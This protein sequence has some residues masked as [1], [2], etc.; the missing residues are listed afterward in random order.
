MGD[1]RVPVTVITGFLGAGK[2]TLL[3]HI[4]SSKEHGLRFAV[5]ENEFGDVSIDDGI[6]RQQSEE[7][8][9]EM[10]NGCVCCTVRGD[11]VKVVKKLLNRDGKKFDAILLETTGMADPS[12]VA[13]T[14]FVDKEIK[15][16]CRLDGIITMVDAKYILDHLAETRENGKVNESHQQIAFA[17]RIVLNKIDLVTRPEIDTIKSAIGA[18]NSTASVIETERSVT[19]PANLIGIRGFDLD[20]VIEFESG[21][22]DVHHKKSHGHSHGHHHDSDIGS[23]SFRSSSDLSAP[24]LQQWLR[25]LVSTQNENLYRYKGIVALKGMDKK[26]VFQGVHM[27]VEG[28]FTVPWTSGET[29]ESKVVFIGRHLDKKQ[30]AADFNKC[31]TKPLRFVVG[32]QVQVRFDGEYIVGT[33]Q[34]TWE[35]GFAYTVRVPGCEKVLVPVDT[36]AFIRVDCDPNT[37]RVKRHKVCVE[38]M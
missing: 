11:L 32:A 34:T 12:P 23:I 35:D 2:T 25:K 36:D 13:Q 24:L 7:Q 19:S 20:R 21:F 14:F 4:L 30:L 6:V 22:L 18:I 15:A 17:D 31:E 1:E 9:L 3:N 10:M 37:D 28:D 33:V 38:Q 29:R 26:Y 8:I 5:I 16:S 27:I